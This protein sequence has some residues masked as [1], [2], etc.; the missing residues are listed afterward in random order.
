MTREKR[1]A[2]SRKNP[3]ADDDVL[4]G[5]FLSLPFGTGSSYHQKQLIAQ[6]RAEFEAAAKQTDAFADSKFPAGA[7][8]CQKCSTAAVVMMDGCMTCLNC[9]DSKCG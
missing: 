3:R 4:L 5:F 1:A 9:G 8:L 7:Q 2:E 6:K